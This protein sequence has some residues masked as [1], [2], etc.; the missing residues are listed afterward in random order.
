M[1]TKLESRTMVRQLIDDP[2][3]ARWT[4]GNLDMLIQMVIDLKWSRILEHSSKMLVQTDTIAAA[5]VTSPGYISMAPSG[6]GGDLSQRLFR[7]HQVARAGKV[8]NLADYLG[9][10]IEANLEVSVGEQG[11]FI[12]G[13][14]LWLVPLDATTDVEVVYSY[15]PAVFTTLGE[16][17]LVIWPDGYE[18]VWIWEAAAAAMEKGAAEDS[19]FL[20]ERSDEGLKDLLGA[21]SRI[22]IAPNRVIV[23]DDGPIAYGGS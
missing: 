13:E 8:F 7:I 15:R 14:Q 18:L 16:G 22:T 5:D 12:R 23:A 19:R 4:N 9:Q 1:L 10:F 17:D 2:N 3:A 11:F 6:L 21:A 20:Q